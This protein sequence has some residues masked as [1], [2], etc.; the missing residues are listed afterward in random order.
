MVTQQ[1][2]PRRLGMWEKMHPEFLFFG[3]IA[4]TLVPKD[5][6]SSSSDIA[7]LPML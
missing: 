3:S 1:R 4:V 7:R 6:L 2:L 5:G